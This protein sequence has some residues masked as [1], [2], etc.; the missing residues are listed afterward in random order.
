MG[1]STDVLGAYGIVRRAR[2]LEGDSLMRNG[3]TKS[4]TTLLRCERELV[5]V[6][7][8]PSQRTRVVESLLRTACSEFHKG[9]RKALAGVAKARGLGSG[10][11]QVD[12]V[13]AGVAIESGL[14]RLTSGVFLGRKAQAAAHRLLQLP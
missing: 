2:I 11:T 9:T 14:Q 4:L 7:N 3:L 13:D 12:M 10:S 8:A 6:G 1:L 5:T